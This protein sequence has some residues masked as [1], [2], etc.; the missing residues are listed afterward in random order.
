MNRSGLIAYGLALAAPVNTADLGPA[1]AN[2]QQLARESINPLVAHHQHLLSP[3]LRL[4]WAPAQATAI[5]LPDELA[6]VLR[7]RE[8]ISGNKDT[9]DIYTEDAL[10]VQQGERSP[11]RRGR[12]AARNF[13]STNPAT[14]RFIPIA[15]S[16]SGTSGQIAGVVRIGA[17]GNWRIAVENIMGKSPPTYAKPILAADLIRQMDD[18]G[19]RRAVLLGMGYT[20]GSPLPPSNGNPVRQGHP[21]E[22]ERVRG[23]ND[24]TADQAALFPDRLVAFCGIN[25]LRDYAIKEVARCAAD[26]RF[27]GIKLHFG[28][29]GVD[30][31]KPEHVK[32]IRAFFAAANRAKL[33]IAVHL[34]TLDPK[35]GAVDSRIFLREILPVARNIPIQVAHMAGAGTYVHDDALEV[36]ADAV[37]KKD[38]LTRN[39]YFDL[40][41]AVDDKTPADKVAQLTS[42]I[43]QIGVERVV[44]GSD[45]APNPD[46][47]TAWAMFRKRIPLTDA[48]VSAIAGNEAPY[49]RDW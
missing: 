25:P 5:E 40:T 48:E 31:E 19:V 24:W 16:F 9:T 45:L 28:N 12:A 10:F 7:E 35:Y 42:R 39:L 20:Y 34:W 26:R 37:A 36:F 43:R 14:G 11:W 44:F 32:Q 30:L 27:R 41:G 47:R 13:A 2:A 49:M 3:S 38:P 33:A 29:S 4:V 18:A 23:E 17:D 6:Q 8:R 15:Y 46:L 1:R 22:Y 21:R